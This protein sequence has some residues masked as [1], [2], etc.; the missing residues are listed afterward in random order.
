MAPFNQSGDARQRVFA[1]DRQG[2][3]PHRRVGP[4]PERRDS[5]GD[6]VRRV[7]RI[8]TEQR[9]RAAE[10]QLLVIQI[11]DRGPGAAEVFRRGAG[12]LP[13]VQALQ[14]GVD[15]LSELRFQ[16]LPFNLMLTGVDE[17][18]PRVRRLV[19]G[20]L[21]ADASRSGHHAEARQHEPVAGERQV[22]PGLERG[23]RLADVADL[24]PE[25]P[26]VGD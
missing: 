26:P 23:V 25:M 24:V 4:F 16:R 11:V 2:V 18:D 20:P 6:V 21:Q 5:G 10:L 12:L 8:D 17:F 15:E 14:H 7:E 9:R 1:G 19:P 13:A 22:V 3:L